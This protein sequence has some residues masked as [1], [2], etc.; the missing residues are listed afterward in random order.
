MSNS[1][2][3]VTEMAPMPEMSKADRAFLEHRRRVETTVLA[4]FAMPGWL[5]RRGSRAGLR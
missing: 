5:V 3:E 1:V 4:V 2:S